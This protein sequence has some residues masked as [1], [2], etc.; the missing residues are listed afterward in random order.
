MYTNGNVPSQPVEA[1]TG[2]RSSAHLP[3]VLDDLLD[4]RKANPRERT[5]YLDFRMQQMLAS[6]LRNP[7]A[8]MY[9][10]YAL[11]N[12]MQLGAASPYSPFIPMSLASVDPNIDPRDAAT[13]ATDSMQ[14]RVDV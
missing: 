9:S 12:A 13:N 10:P 14:K 5:R 6:Q 1:P 7:Y 8:T 11:Q 2:P 4:P 3:A